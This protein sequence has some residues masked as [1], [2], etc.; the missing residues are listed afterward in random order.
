[1][2][3]K[4]EISRNRWTDKQWA[5]HLDTSVERVPE[6]RAAIKNNYS[7]T[8]V[9]DK[10]TGLYA[11]AIFTYE[12]TPSGFKRPILSTTSKKEFVKESDAIVFANKKYLPVLSLSKFAADSINVPAN[13]IQML[14]IKE[15]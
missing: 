4:S 6:I 15:R 14:H 12:M 3:K 8:I 9:M 13:A 7:A 5:K 11:I 2:S 1:M 10:I